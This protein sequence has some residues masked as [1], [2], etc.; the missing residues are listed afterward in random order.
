MSTAPPKARSP[1]GTAL[2][3]SARIA[4]KNASKAPTSFSVTIQPNPQPT[5]GLSDND[6]QRLQQSM[7][8]YPNESSTMDTDLLEYEKLLEEC[9]RAAPTMM[10]TVRAIRE[11]MHFLLWR[12]KLLDSLSTEQLQELHGWMVD[13][14]TAHEKWNQQ[15]AA[16]MMKA[17]RS[18]MG[19]FIDLKADAYNP[20]DA[21]KLLRHWQ[22][23][24]NEFTS[25]HIDVEL[26]HERIW[27]RL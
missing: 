17:I 10:P 5:L 24:H 16:T 9:R 12:N 13:F 22:E 23:D 7:P 18:N 6:L 8:A 1:C 19:Y 26:I 20:G 27:S 11:L 3:R 25:T 2:R 4:A 15:F 14:H 21:M